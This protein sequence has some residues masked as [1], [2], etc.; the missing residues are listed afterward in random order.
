MSN[1]IGYLQKNRTIVRPENN[2]F[3]QMRTIKGIITFGSNIPLFTFALKKMVPVRLPAGA[4][5]VN[6]HDPDDILD[7]PPKPI[8]P[9]Y[10]RAVRRDTAINVGGLF[11]SWNPLPHKGYWTDNDFTKPV[12]HFISRLL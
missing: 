6:Y 3:E 12:G 11:L 2:R 8:S 7:Y 10:L 1:Y 9:A 5:W 4:T